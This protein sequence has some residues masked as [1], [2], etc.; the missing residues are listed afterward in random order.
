MSNNTL[1]RNSYFDESS[2]SPAER[3]D[4]ESEGPKNMW[5]DVDLVT[6]PQTCYV[7]RVNSSSMELLN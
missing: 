2:S 4:I 6:M 1:L 3:E 7:E 5:D